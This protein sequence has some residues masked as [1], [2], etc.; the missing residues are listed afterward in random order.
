M[1]VPDI[2]AAFD[3]VT[4]ENSTTHSIWVKPYCPPAESNVNQFVFFLKPETTDAKNGVKVKECTE[5]ALNT[6]TKAGVKIGAIR[7]VGGTYLDKHDIMVQHYGVISKISKEGLPAI[8]EQAKTVLH[9]KFNDELKAG[10][11]VLGGHQ[12]L[13]K[14]KQFNPFSLLVVNDNLGT[15]R[16]AGGTY[17]M[18]I[19]VLGKLFLVLNPFHSFQL[20]PYTTA[21]NAIIVFEGLST[22]PFEDLRSK[23][24]GVTD[25]AAALPGSIRNQFLQNKAALGLKDVDKG[26]NGLH[27]SAGPLEGL[28]ELQRFFSDHEA[29]KIVPLTSFAFGA[30]V[31]SK[32]ASDDQVSKFASNP[33]TLHNGKNTSLFDLTEEKSFDVAADLLLS[34]KL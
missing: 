18:K 32:G 27:L 21:G 9:E 16:L 25:P 7:V 12:F 22:L 17:L 15:T 33:N 19:K 8:S 1:S 30:Y 6:L 13:A 24:A 34:A 29:G 3:K 31:K 23:L 10:A 5:L 20:V 14:F 2:I 11:E 26:T 4:A 28:V